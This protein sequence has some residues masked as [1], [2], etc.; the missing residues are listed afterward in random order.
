MD[1]SINVKGLHLQFRT[2]SMQGKRTDEDLL[3]LLKDKGVDI[4]RTTGD[5]QQWS[6]SDKAEKRGNSNPG[7]KVFKGEK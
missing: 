3:Q 1:K 7:G 5:L 2:V 6:Y 4:L